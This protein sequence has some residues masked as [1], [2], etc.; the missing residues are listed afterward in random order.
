MPRKHTEFG[1]ANRV[2]STAEFDESVTTFANAIA[3]GPPL[4]Y[5][6]AKRAVYAS[7]GSSLDDALEREVQGQLQCIQSNDFIEGVAAFLQKRDPEFKGR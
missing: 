5:K 1:L 6:L 4:P 2:Y 3:K 7:W